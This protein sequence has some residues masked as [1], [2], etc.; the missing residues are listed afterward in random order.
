MEERDAYRNTPSILATLQCLPEVMELTSESSWQMFLALQ[1]QDRNACAP[2]QPCDLHFRV[3]S[4]ADEDPGGLT[5]QAVMAE[6]RRLNRVAPCAAEWAKLHDLLRSAGRGNP[7]PALT[8]AEAAST[9]ALVQ[10]IQV[11]DQVEWAAQR[12]MLER[13]FEFLQDLPESRWTHIGR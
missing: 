3:S 11:R 8:A 7:P 1:A 10:R 6:A 13:V 12:G 4:A 9:P 5:V 2:T